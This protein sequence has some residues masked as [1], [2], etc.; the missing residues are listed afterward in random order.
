[1]ARVLGMVCSGRKGGYTATLLAEMLSGAASVE[2]VE[3]QTIYV[4]NHQFSPCI[5]CFDCIRNPDHTCVLDDAFGRRGEGPLF[6]KVREANGLV[7]ATPVHNYGVSAIAHLV[8]ERC[9]P[10]VWSDELNGMPFAGIVCASNQGMHLRALEELCKF[11]YTLGTRWIDGL[12]VH[13]SFYQTALLKARVMGKRL[14]EAASVDETEGRKRFSDVER[15][16]YYMPLPWNPLDWMM[17][18]LK[19]ID[20]SLKGG[21][22]QRLEAIELLEKAGP[23]Y[24]EAVRYHRL[25]NYEEAIKHLNA[26][27]SYWTRATW[28][29]YLELQVIGAAPPKAYRPLPGAY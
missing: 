11:A 21:T 1:L 8:V 10:F 25:K 9:Y 5:S 20:R 15:M 22:F 4:S 7:I 27:L 6:K 18:N 17:E 26:A 29:E 23:E 13:T 19:M 12:A 3:T 2:G 16:L 24:Q 28:A 14:A